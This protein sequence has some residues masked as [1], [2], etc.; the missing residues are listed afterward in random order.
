MGLINE[1]FGSCSSAATGQKDGGMTVIN[2]LFNVDSCR[3]FLT[4]SHETS[5]FQVMFHAFNTTLL[6]FAFLLY[7]FIVVVGTINTARDGKILGKDYDAYWLP[8][9]VV[10]G[11]LA[12]VPAKSGYC[13]AQLIIYLALSV[14]VNMANIVWSKAYDKA[15]SGQVA[16]VV[17]DELKQHLKDKLS[18]YYLHNMVAQEFNQTLAEKAE[19]DPLKPELIRKYI[20]LPIALSNGNVDPTQFKTFNDSVNSELNKSLEKAKQSQQTVFSP[21]MINGLQG[22]F[23]SLLSQTDVAFRD[24]SGFLDDHGELQFFQLG[25]GST[26]LNGI[27]HFSMGASSAIS[28]V[29]PVQ[30]AI[31]ETIGNYLKQADGKGLNNTVQDIM[32]VVMQDGGEGCQKQT[33][34]PINIPQD[35][36]QKTDYSWWDADRNYLNLDAG[37]SQGL[38]KLYST[39]AEF[40][41]SY[42]ISSD[43]T[44]E[45]NSQYLNAYVLNK[46]NK[47]NIYPMRI[48]V[49]MS[50]TNASNKSFK[51][52]ISALNIVNIKAVRE[53]YL[54]LIGEKEFHNTVPYKRIID[55]LITDQLRPE[56][57]GYLN[58]IYLY[59][60]S[61]LDHKDSNKTAPSK[62]AARMVNFLYEANE[63]GVDLFVSKS[64]AAG[65]ENSVGTDPAKALLDDIYS[66]VL[67]KGQDT[68]KDQAKGL[69]DKIYDF[70]SKKETDDHI[71]GSFSTIKRVQSLGI[72]LMQNTIEQ[73]L[74]IY[75][76]ASN[77][78]KK[79]TDDYQRSLDDVMASSTGDAVL[80]AFF[81]FVSGYL[82][83]KKTMEFAKASATTAIEMA[84]FSTSLMWL[85]LIFYVL[86]TI[87]GIGATFALIVPLTPFILFWA[88]KM[89]WLLLAIEAM[90]AAPIMAL[91]IVYPEGH[92]VFGKAQSG[93]QMMIGLLFR[94]VLMILGLIAGITL[95]YIVINFSASG[96]HAIADQLTSFI[97][98]SS[99]YAKG[100]FV[101]LLTFLY[102]TFIGIAFHKCFS[103]IYL[104]PDKVMQW[105]G[106]QA[107]DRAGEQ[108]FQEMK[109]A[110]T[111]QSQQMAQ[112][113]SQ[114]ATQGIETQKQNNKELQQKYE[115][116]KKS[117]YERDM[118]AGKAIG[119]GVSETAQTAA[120]V[121][122]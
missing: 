10:L 68:R 122:V 63:N 52:D 16:P 119:Q 106:H 93:I 75:A 1:L 57:K 56:Y 100:S 25:F 114:A 29:D 36:P 85:P 81:P 19:E 65:G 49:P 74:A 5:I 50:N 32:C 111:Q 61:L 113:G 17:P 98:D 47:D 77:G 9:R 107:G 110:A 66:E 105:I 45:L 53:Q 92:K 20:S 82:Q 70:A 108:V 28:A 44:V 26:T 115:S 101:L 60:T 7:A 88:G 14:G 72:S 2:A 42:S 48:Q 40:D 21:S 34:I 13:I 12:V 90:V 121:M 116:E 15:I 46:F 97:P 38:K 37:L 64:A 117:E 8:L 120:K 6:T 41:K 55:V 109:T 43:G 79:I 24:T 118:A 86:T 3:D 51:S 83:A 58:L 94:P 69:L 73:M 59:L 96:F 99:A 39:L 18:I 95:T 84:K 22:Y 104:V 30:K 62:L 112:S 78:F 4:V 80:A 71:M 67:G 76:H 33:N 31:S 35:N 89:A 87:F 91:G 11:T 23:S 27:Y 103:M 102:A 54:N